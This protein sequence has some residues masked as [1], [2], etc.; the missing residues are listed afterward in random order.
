MNKKLTF[1]LL[2]AVFSIAA[3]AQG[4]PSGYGGVMLQGF[5][6][7][8]FSD[9]QWTNLTNEAND[10]KG[11]IDLLWIP[12][13]GQCL[14]TNQMGY[15]PYYFFPVGNNYNSSFG[16][17][18]QLRSM[19]SA[20]NAANI[21]VLGDVV[22][23]HHNTQG[24]FGFPSETYNGVTYQLL[25][26]DVV[27]DDDNG[28][29]LAYAQSNG[30]TLSNNNDSGEG[31]PALRDLDH[32]SAN[33]QNYVK[34]YL[35]MLLTDLG[36]KGFR[37]D[38]VKG[39]DASF[40]GTYNTYAQPDFS[41]GECWGTDSEIRSWIDGTKV[42]NTPTSAAFD[43]QFRYTIR[44]AINGSDWRK[45]NEAN[46]GSGGY[47]LV[48][49]SNNNGSYRQWAIT[50]VEN[51]DTQYR[52]ANNT[53]DPI[54]ADTLAA[55]AYM[56]AMPGT[57]CVFY[58]HWKA[59]KKEIKNMIAIRK[60]AG[61]TNTCA[62]TVRTSNQKNYYVVSSTGSV[63]SMRAAVGPGA[64]SYN[65]PSTSEK[66]VAEGYH[67]KYYLGQSSSLNK[68]WLTKP[69]GDY[70]E[71]FDVTAVKLSQSNNFVM[72][73]TT[74]GTDPTANSTQIADGGTIHID[75][76]MTVKI[77]LYNTSTGRVNTSSMETREY[78]VTPTYKITVYLKDPTE[79]L[80]NHNI[81]TWSHI[82]CKMFQ[83][84]DG[85]SEDTSYGVDITG[86]TKVINGV[87]YYYREFESQ[88]STFQFNML[89]CNG[90]WGNDNQ[91]S[92][93]S[94]VKV[95]DG[96][97]LNEYFY[98]LTSGGGNS[99]LTATQ[100]SDTP[101]QSTATI[102]FKV[103]DS[104]IEGWDQ[105]AYYAWNGGTK[106]L[107]NWP[108]KRLDNDNDCKT[109]ING[110]EYYYYTF[111]KETEDY[112]FTL[113][114]NN[115]N[116]GKQTVD[117]PVTGDAFYELGPVE[118]GK[119][120]VVTPGSFQPHTAT[121]YLKL[122]EGHDWGNEIHCFAWDDGSQVNEQWP[123]PATE[124]A[125]IDGVQYYKRTFNIPTAS[126]TVNVIFNNND[127][128]KQTVDITGVSQDTYLELTNVQ[129]DNGHYAVKDPAS[130][131]Y[132]YTAT[133]YFKD[134]GWDAVYYYV[135][136]NAG[137][138]PFG[139]WAG[140]DE[141]QKTVSINGE[142]WHYG[143][144]LFDA[145]GR[146][147]NVIFNNNNGTQTEDITGITSD[148]YYKLKGEVDGNNHQKVEV[149]TPDYP[150]ATI[151]FKQPATGWDNINFHA[152]ASGKVMNPDNTPLADVWPGVASEA[153][154][155]ID[156]EPWYYRTFV[157]GDDSSRAN[158][159]INN[160]SGAQTVNVEGIGSDVYYQL[161]GTQ[162][163]ESHYNVTNAGDMTETI[164]GIQLN[165]HEFRLG[166]HATLPLKATVNGTHVSSPV[167]WTSSNEKLVTVT[168]GSISPVPAPS[169][170]GPRRSAI[171]EGVMYGAAVGTGDNPQGGY[172]TI[173]ATIG[174]FSD[175]CQ[176]YVDV[177]TGNC[178]IISEEPLVSVTNGTIIIN[179]PHATMA[180]FIGPDG[181][182]RTVHVKAGVNTYDFNSPIVIV[183]IDDKVHKLRK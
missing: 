149:A 31:W 114:I 135:W 76:D 163:G 45:L 93:I 20:M 164:T 101:Q 56:L 87:T 161:D 177:T 41:V 13:A 72:V 109:T 46:T 43:F 157:L 108:G 165:Y 18:S 180:Q 82:Y 94:N 113:I 51:H 173:T 97:L 90:S 126:Y 7:N 80:N 143:I 83:A 88:S 61:I 27:R 111:E 156:G 79:Y 105:V 52:D 74:D 84:N 116:N 141:T 122:P 78:T 63:V 60:L 86:N 171:V 175:A 181:R 11:Y 5:S 59:Y 125:T 142:T 66:L 154:K 53:N 133:V 168:P 152:W 100:M 3:F 10:M 6:W 38:M 172:A 23:N 71:A 57:P 124:T 62:L 176:V 26:T 183:K 182:A 58:P 139:G 81:N 128:G 28:E 4:W 178:T 40:I 146:T 14:G 118:N 162:D 121:V 107:G 25:S 134:P 68:A 16:N 36:Y 129:D 54:T 170:D 85:R 104:S 49:A 30:Y 1:F 34:A 153:I 119:Y 140:H 98:E 137:N 112:E 65:N 32:N 151:Y 174:G 159:V 69:S 99:R 67:Y 179:S 155:Y 8:S 138:N 55:N 95:I 117:I 136:D 17:L 2:N 106:L 120:T 33:V 115:N 70:S 127:N 48:S 12:N 21:G 42:N 130:E 64:A 150:T 50:F 19:V 75:R 24:W 110:V 123:G 91:T 9:T 37:Y 145:P 96:N 92:N 131:F 166:L 158:V 160:G 167:V 47:P 102:Y 73:Y 169:S 35:N 132:P 29:A 39:Y 103:P 77:A 44:N 22:I 89:F 147:F 15:S 144:L 148:I